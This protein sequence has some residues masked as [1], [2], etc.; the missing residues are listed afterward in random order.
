MLK[1]PRIDIGERCINHTDNIA[2]FT[3]IRRLN[4]GGKWVSYLAQ[5]SSGDKNILTYLD[6]EAMF[7][8]YRF[9]AS[10]EGTPKEDLDKAA[11]KSVREHIEEEEKRVERIRDLGNAQVGITY[12]YSL[13]LARE[14]MVVI[15]EYPAGVDL[16]YAASKIGSIQ[17]IYVF[18]QVLEGLKYIHKNGFLH[19]N[20]KPSRIYVDMDNIVPSVKI[21]DFGFAI[22]IGSNE[23]DA[24]GTLLYMAPEVLL[25]QNNRIDERADLFSL[26]VVMY[27]CMTKQQPFEYRIMNSQLSKKERIELELS[28]KNPI[29]RPSE[30]SK[31]LPDGLETIIMGLLERDPDKRPYSNAMDLLAAFHEKWPNE[32]HEMVINRVTL[33]TSE[34]EQE[35]EIFPL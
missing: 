3:I 8:K 34:E 32:S 29:I 9:I 31:K 12:D 13:D 27:N 4:S 21:S 7:E 2:D 23:C 22:P 5:S 20:L 28:Q 18:A 24:K 6:K 1:P 26:G 25:C 33:L 10:R 35:P 16:T 15:S 30:Y 19:L 11:H 17:L 14:E